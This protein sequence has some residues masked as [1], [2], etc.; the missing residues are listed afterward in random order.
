ME[1]VWKRLHTE[2]AVEPKQHG[3]ASPRNLTQGDL[4]LIETWKKARP[5]SSSREIHDVVNEFGDIPN[6]TSISAIARSLRRNMLSGLK[7][8]RRKISSVA[9]ERFTIENMAY[10]HVRRLPSHKKPS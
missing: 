4:Q 9:Q 5:T 8:T 6:G 3:G 2:R 10:T 7:Y 1:K